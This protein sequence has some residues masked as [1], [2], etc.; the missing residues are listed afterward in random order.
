M[1]IYA[2]KNTR[3]VLSAHVLQLSFQP[4]KQILEDTDLFC[5]Q[6]K[7]TYVSGPNGCGKTSLL[8]CSLGIYP[9]LRGGTFKGSVYFLEGNRKIV[10]SE[11]T[12]SKLHT[13]SLFIGQDPDTCIIAPTVIEE[14]VFISVVRGK[15]WKSSIDQC[16]NLAESTGLS[17]LLFRKI[18]TLSQGQKQLVSALGAA[19]SNAEIAFFD[20]PFSMLDSSA[21]NALSKALS[22]LALSGCSIVLTGVHGDT[23]I[24]KNNFIEISVHDDIRSNI[25]ENSLPS[26]VS[27]DYAIEKTNVKLL[28]NLVVSLSE[29]ID[30]ELIGLEFWYGNEWSIGPKSQVFQNGNI[31]LLYGANGCGK[32]TLLRLISGIQ[33]LKRGKILLNGID[34]FSRNMRPNKISYV[35][36]NPEHGIISQTILEELL[37]NYRLLNQSHQGTEQLIALWNEIWDSEI[38]L[39]KNPRTLSYGQKKILSIL[40]TGFL[41]DLVVIDEPFVGLDIKRIAWVTALLD[42]L[43]E[44]GKIII[45]SGHSPSYLN[46]CLTPINLDKNNES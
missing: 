25:Y 14:L 32:S 27:L 44:K 31:Y 16:I 30:L 42:Y 5:Y 17:D 18:S 12:I 6:G 9:Y 40:S 10:L 33:K 23:K 3:E 2:S 45:I 37:L 15:S 24:T 22:K 19:L 46:L 7:I 41:S 13:K 39:D 29:K 36:Q 34:V 38:P 26:K 4:N 21:C 35:P 43:R 20:E 1:S 11:H 28:D 8:L